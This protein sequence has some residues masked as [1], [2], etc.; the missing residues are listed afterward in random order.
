M[1]N[2]DIYSSSL[3]GMIFRIVLYLIVFSI[4]GWHLSG[5]I[6]SYFMSLSNYKL[7][8]V[9]PFEM[10]NVRFTICTLVGILLSLPLIYLEIY[11]FVSPALYNA[12][13]KIIILST[14]PIFGM[15]LIGFVFTLKIFIPTVLNYL[16]IFYVS[17][18]STTVTIA[19][20]VSFI[21]SFLLIFGIIFCMP[22]FL[23]ILSYLRIINYQLLQKYQKHVILGIV[24]FSAVITPDPFI[25][26]C[27]IVSI[28]L[29]CL[30]EVST[31][32]VYLV[33][34]SNS[35]WKTTMTQ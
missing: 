2:I 30:Y 15:V 29:I 26:T 3:K 6:L 10:L 16:D 18:I 23:G 5:Y 4:V 1:S 7:I 8:T 35:P 11:N 19:N 13:K 31:I 17:E 20:Y 25:F 21:I 27:L 28:P 34:R 24:I 9:E 22:I 32:I 33:G 14:L 12:E